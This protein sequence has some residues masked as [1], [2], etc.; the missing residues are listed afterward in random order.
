M[1]KK[2]DQRRQNFYKKVAEMFKRIS[3]NKSTLKT[4]VYSTNSPNRYHALLHKVLLN[5]KLLLDINKKT[6][7]MQNKYLGCIIIYEIINGK[8]R[9]DGYRRKFTKALGSN[10]FVEPKE[11]V[12]VRINTNKGN[13]NDLSELEIE[14]TCVENVF[15][16]TDCKIKNMSVKKYIESNLQG[17]VKIQS[18]ESCLPAFILNPEENSTIIDATAAPGN[19][20][21]HLS[22]LLKNTGEIL[23]YEKDKSR[24]EI[25]EEQVKNYGA[26]NIQ[27]F[28]QDFLTV[29]P[30]SIKPD[31]ITV[32][33][34][35]SGSG[36][37]IDYNK[38]DE[39]IAK[40]KNFQCMMLNH[41][42]KFQAKKVIYSVCSIHEEEGEQVVQEALEKN[43]N[44]ELDTIGDFWSQRGKKEYEFSEKVVRSNA[45]EEGSKGFFIALFK[46]KE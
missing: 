36:I 10:K 4:E 3:Q 37:H 6:D 25:L 32:D 29:D 5:G 35:C 34:S 8:L 41:A 46:K 33:P 24:F 12:Y 16:I 18:L 26:K 1:F 44:Y 42:L 45:T 31:Y 15:K 17:Q 27:C 11:R 22:C 13:I 2:L 21:T 7:Y 28:H 40:L 9:N 19:K 30:T 20:T 14:K 39:R 23:A 38:N 43:P